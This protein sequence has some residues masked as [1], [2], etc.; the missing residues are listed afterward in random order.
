MPSISFTVLPFCEHF[1]IE[2]NVILLLAIHCIIKSRL[3]DIEANNDE[4]VG[5]HFEV[6]ARLRELESYE[7]DDLDVSH[8]KQVMESPYADDNEFLE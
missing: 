3:I 8:E 6:N 7:T 5:S 4:I 2:K 1:D